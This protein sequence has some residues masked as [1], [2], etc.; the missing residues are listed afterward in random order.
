MPYLGAEDFLVWKAAYEGLG[1][2]ARHVRDPALRRW[3]AE[4]PQFP[5]ERLQ[6]ANWPA[7][8]G[9]MEAWLAA[10]PAR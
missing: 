2:A 9:E 10:K 8:K 7:L 1:A 5:A 6:K 4:R 3:Y